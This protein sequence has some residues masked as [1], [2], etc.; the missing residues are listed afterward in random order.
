MAPASYPSKLSCIPEGTNTAAGTSTSMLILYTDG[1]ARGNPGPAAIAYAIFDSTGKVLGKGAKFIG[2]RT[3]NEAEYEAVLW[4]L[5]KV[6]ERSCDVVRVITDSELVARQAS[7]EYRARDPR[8]KQYADKVAI[9][10]R[11]FDAF[12]IAHSRRDDER[13]ALVDALVNAELEKR[14]HPKK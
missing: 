6:R 13:V 8:M 2:E 9:N 14:G 12:E 11:L 4:G 1:G 10:R 5:E 3:N 7:G